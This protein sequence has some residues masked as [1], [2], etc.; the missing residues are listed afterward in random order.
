MQ[1]KPRYE[2]W[3]R[4]TTGAAIE[5]DPS[6]GISEDRALRNRLKIKRVYT[7]E[8]LQTED[9]RN[10]FMALR[11]IV[12]LKASGQYIS[13]EEIGQMLEESESSGVD[14]QG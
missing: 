12:L 8:M 2:T 11:K 9:G 1:E 4:I 13:E 3:D 5:Y 14:L 10:F 7:H 6:S